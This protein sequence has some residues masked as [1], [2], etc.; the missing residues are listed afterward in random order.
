[1]KLR[2]LVGGRVEA[3]G[4]DN[5]LLEAARE[6]L[7]A[8]TGSLAV[9]RDGRLAGVLTERDVLRAVAGGVDTE[10][11]LVGQWMSSE[12]DT[13]SPEVEVEEAAQW[14]LEAGYR[15][16]PVLEHDELIGIISIRDLLWA[17]L[18]PATE[19]PDVH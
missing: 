12:P 14:L 13:V 9:I 11:A 7:E 1:V 6:M 4:P 17:I 8:S 10:H 15:H 2:N 16:L 19:P 18:A 5:T 3:C